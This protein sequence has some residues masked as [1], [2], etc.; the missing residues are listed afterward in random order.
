MEQV[1]SHPTYHTRV[2]RTTHSN[3]IDHTIGNHKSVIYQKYSASHVVYILTIMA[4]RTIAE[5]TT[6][7]KR[8]KTTCT[9]MKL[10]YTVHFICWILLIHRTHSNQSTH[11]T[12]YTQTSVQN[13]PCIIHHSRS[14]R[15]LLTIN[16]AFRTASFYLCKS[17]RLQCHSCAHPSFPLTI[18]YTH[19]HTYNFSWSALK[20]QQPS[21]HKKKKRKFRY[22]VTTRWNAAEHP[23]QYHIWNHNTP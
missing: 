17:S 14:Q 6:R 3:N 12:T 20:T 21:I 16:K 4:M 7:R 5:N 9:K 10:S 22:D 23:L 13:S 18:S 19:K 2:H 1:S 15:V 11:F 8:N